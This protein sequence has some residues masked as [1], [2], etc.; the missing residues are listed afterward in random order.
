[1]TRDFPPRHS[2]GL[3]T[4]VGGLVAAQA[5]A[6]MHSVVVSFDDFKASSGVDRSQEA[7][8]KV[9]DEGIPIVRVAADVSLG[10]AFELAAQQAGTLVHLHHEGLWDFASDLAARLR[11]PLVY[12]V[13]VLQSQ[14][15]RLRG[16]T[17]TKSTEAQYRALRGADRLH[18][19]SQTVSRLLGEIDPGLPAKAHTI[20]LAAEPCAP[21]SDGPP[22]AEAQ[23]P[24]VLY[25]GRF[26]D[27]NGFQQF[28]SALPPL[29]AQCPQ[30]RAV[31]A[32]GLPGN[33]RGAKRWRKRWDAMA[34]GDAHRLEMPNWLGREDLAA[35]Y[36]QATL[37]V[38][39]SWFETFGQVALEGMLHGTP[40]LT[41]GAGALAELVDS[42]SALLMK[43]KDTEAIIEGVLQILADPA[44]AQSRAA[45][46]YEKAHTDYQWSARMPAFRTLYEE[47]SA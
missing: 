13:H 44:A 39:P 8:L 26:A 41:T 47:A 36:R 14:Q 38:V 29:F 6:G 11:L 25:V 1:M 31:A 28:L 35:L 37:L 19:P 33:E 7:V 27:I 45:I 24:L 46:A 15:D 42:Q 40:L 9:N 5:K 20:R 12:S 43:A 17:A 4:A 34:G 22:R 30:L 18:A 3:S 16:I 2:G 23:S 21:A 32:G 10:S